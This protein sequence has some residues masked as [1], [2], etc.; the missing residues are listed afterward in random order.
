M[1]K[2]EISAWRNRRLLLGME[3]LSRPNPITL[4]QATELNLK[5][6]EQVEKIKDANLDLSSWEIGL[7]DIE[8]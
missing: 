7:E 5:E 8:I 3:I 4:A 6:I 1:R 2:I